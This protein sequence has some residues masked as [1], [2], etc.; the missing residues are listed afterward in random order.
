VFIITGLNEQV[1]HLKEY[2]NKN[3]RKNYCPNCKQKVEP[4][5]ERGWT[6]T[7]VVTL[8]VTVLFG[9]FLGVGFFIILFLADSISLVNKKCPICCCKYRDL[10]YRS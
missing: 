6:I 7:I 9:L 10:E 4:K 8:L 1:V 3:F 5:R 2:F